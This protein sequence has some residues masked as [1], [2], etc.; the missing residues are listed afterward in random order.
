MVLTQYQW[1]PSMAEELL[2]SYSHGRFNRDIFL[3]F[4]PVVG[5]LASSTERQCAADTHHQHWLFTTRKGWHRGSGCWFPFNYYMVVM[6]EYLP[7]NK[8]ICKIV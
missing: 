3:P 2:E 1:Q 4:D 6:G 8:C 5:D 7:I